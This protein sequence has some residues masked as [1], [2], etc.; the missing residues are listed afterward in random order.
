MESA[1]VT[2]KLKGQIKLIFLNFPDFEQAIYAYMV[3]EE[4][5][6]RPYFIR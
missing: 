1:E 4:M 6:L 3:M 2:E 5:S